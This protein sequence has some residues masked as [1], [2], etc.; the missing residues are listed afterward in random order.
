MSDSSNPQNGSDESKRRKRR[1][2]VRNPL[3]SEQYA[4]IRKGK[5][6]WIEYR[7]QSK[8]KIQLR[9][10]DLS[11]VDLQET[12]LAKAVFS[13]GVL[14]RANL[15]RA[16]L[17]GAGLKGVTLI[18]TDLRGAN[19]R[20]VAG[21]TQQQIDQAI[22]DDATLLPK[23]LSHPHSANPVPV[24]ASISDHPEKE[25]ASDVAPAKMTARRRRSNPRAR[26]RHLI[27]EGANAAL[28]IMDMRNLIEDGISQFLISRE[29]N[30]L[31]DDAQVVSIFSDCLAS[32]ASAISKNEEVELLLQLEKL[33][34][35]LHQILEELSCARTSSSGVG[36]FWAKFRD[37]SADNLSDLL[38]KYAPIGIGA[39]ATYIY[40]PDLGENLLGTILDGFTNAEP[41]D[42]LSPST[43][44]PKTWE[45]FDI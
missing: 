29:L 37:R 41:S 31:P 35:V 36:T 17:E 42:D 39:S 33:E 45:H 25:I 43:E 15:G 32:I 12:D 23:G 11:G 14:S 2:R 34:G 6:S 5:E 21:L 1:R 18:D 16:N 44:D 40:G 13:N 28:T 3:N 19:L 22:V 26:A 7:G 27:N 38:F 8:A 9:G 30:A 10:A 20:R 24:D 4:A